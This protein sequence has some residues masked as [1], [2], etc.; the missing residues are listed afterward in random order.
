[1]IRVVVNIIP[2]LLAVGWLVATGVWNRTEAVVR[3][4]LTARE[5]AWQA[6]EGTM[7]PRLWITWEPRADPLDARNWLTY[8]RLRRLGFDLSVPAAAPSADRIYERM[9]PRRAWV[10]FE[11]DGDAWQAI[12]RRRQLAPGED[13]GDRF[14][15]SSRLVPVDAGPEAAE[16]AERYGDGRHLIIPA[17]IELQWVGPE[18]GGPLVYGTIR[19]LDPPSIT[20]P[21]RLAG[22][23]RALAPAA[24]DRPPGTPP[25]ARAVTTPRYDVELAV[26]RLGI[27][28]IVE[29]R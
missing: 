5:A 14:A 24:P 19:A 4:T 28:W 20:V 7:P 22:Y 29:I 1:V 17:W 12:E 11:H 2:V 23:L 3:V 6:G 26:G 21:S 8:D 15:S 18:T 25:A 9:L 16:L 13:G 10:V 27:P